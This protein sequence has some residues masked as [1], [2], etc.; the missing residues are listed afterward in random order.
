MAF[1]QPKVEKSGETL[2]AEEI[3]EREKGFLERFQ[4]KAREVAKVMTLISGLSLGTACES[5]YHKMRDNILGDGGKIPTEQVSQESINLIEDLTA[6]S[7]D[8][9]RLIEDK[10]PGMIDFIATGNQLTLL[11]LTERMVEQ[12]MN[13]IFTQDSLNVLKGR[14]I[15]GDFLLSSPETNRR[16][17]YEAFMEMRKGVELH[18]HESL[19]ALKEAESALYHR[20][21]KDNDGVISGTE[22][23]FL[24]LTRS[25]MVRVLDEIGGDM[26]DII[27]EK[28]TNN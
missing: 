24:N 23:G 3:L 8:I 6:N 28:E 17:G 7:D 10:S 16:D 21:D 27:E 11:Y 22:Q 4:G 18:P 12:D 19:E 2:D 26:I 20:M 9:Q 5:P 25:G 1:E 15:N 14:V 13:Y